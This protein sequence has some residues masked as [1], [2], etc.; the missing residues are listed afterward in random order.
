M[1]RALHLAHSPRNGKSRRE[2]ARRNRRAG[3]WVDA[4]PAI[5]LILGVL[6]NRAVASVYD[7][8]PAFQRLLRPLL[9]RLRA[10]SVTPNA[11]TIA[12]LVGSAVVGITAAVLGRRRAVLVMIPAW[13]F[14]RMALN[15]LDGMMAREYRMESRLGGI[16]NEAGDV[17]S[18]LFLY[19]PL[20]WIEPDAALAACAFSLGSV[21]TEF[22]GLLSRASGGT[23]RYDGPMGKSDRAFAI[24]ALSLATAVRPGLFAWWPTFLWVAT[25]LTI[26][27][28]ARRLS[29]S[30][31]EMKA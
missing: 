10:G 20:A 27:T 24:G 15:A 17:A 16:L 28:S 11:L 1:P 4:A 23:R 7:L 6:H 19:M 30:L 13:L 21:L 5:P 22:C 18:D 3:A 14:A 12:A 25:A 29:R 8:K 26:V 2:A 9:A 31:S